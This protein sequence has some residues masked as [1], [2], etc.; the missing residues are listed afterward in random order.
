MTFDPLRNYY[1]LENF[2]VIVVGLVSVTYLGRVE[3]VAHDRGIFVQE[4]TR[5]GT[6]D[7]KIF[8]VCRVG[9]GSTA[10]QIEGIE[11]TRW[12]TPSILK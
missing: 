3:T 8:R 12:G 9:T 4:T 11:C 2:A 1:V 10:Y 7:K 6:L 5:C